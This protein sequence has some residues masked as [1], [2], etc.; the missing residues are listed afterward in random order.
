MKNGEFILIFTT[1]PDIAVADKLA[2]LLLKNRLAA[3]VNMIP[4]IISKYWW[5]N[6]IE[7]DSEVMLLIKTH[8]NKFNQIKMEISQNHPYDVPEILSIPVKNGSSDYLEWINN[9]LRVQ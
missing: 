2:D 7:K 8:A 5:K 3:C 4:G 9:S 6:N 1:C